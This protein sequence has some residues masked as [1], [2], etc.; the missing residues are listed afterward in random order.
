MRKPKPTAALSRLERA[1]VGHASEAAIIPHLKVIRELIQ[2]L[3]TPRGRKPKHPWTTT[4]VGESFSLPTNPDNPM[5]T[6]RHV[7]KQAHGYRYR[8]GLEFKVDFGND[9]L[10]TILVT[11][12]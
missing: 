2:P 1:L 7:Q 12:L 8:L 11:R 10:T 4:P 5:S 3:T 9:D 6:F